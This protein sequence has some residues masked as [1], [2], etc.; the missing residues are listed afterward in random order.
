MSDGRDRRLLRRGLV[1]LGA[2]L[3]CFVVLLP[4]L[5]QFRRTATLGPSGAEL[6]GTGAL[7]VFAL[8]LAA[9]ITL[10]ALA[11]NDLLRYYAARDTR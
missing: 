4:L 3:V 8:L 6:T 2:W 11:L 9:A 1:K 7:L 5:G 10:L